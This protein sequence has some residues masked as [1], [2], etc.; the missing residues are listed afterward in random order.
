MDILEHI[1]DLCKERG[2]SIYKLAEES[3][4]TQST[5]ANMFSRKTMP[6]IATLTAICDAFEISL[7]QFF[8]E[9]D[10]NL[11]LSLEEKDLIIA[12][13]QLSK[14]EKNIVK[15]LLNQLKN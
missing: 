14:R 7:S 3:M 15:S 1:K 4:L 9:T 10:S 8:S 6:S 2:W 13:R 11:I 5:L 12:Y